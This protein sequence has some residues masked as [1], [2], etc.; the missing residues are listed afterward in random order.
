MDVRDNAHMQSDLRDGGFRRD[1][2]LPSGTDE[3]SV[4]ATYA[5]GIL[6]IRAP[7]RDLSGVARVVPVTCSEIVSPG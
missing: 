2:R 5:H 1:I 4:T 3:S 6:E 7:M